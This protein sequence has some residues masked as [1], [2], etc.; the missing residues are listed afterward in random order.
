MFVCGCCVCVCTLACVCKVEEYTNW[1]SPLLCCAVLDAIA[2]WDANDAT[3]SKVPH[4]AC[5][6]GVAENQRGD[7]LRG[8]RIGV[9]KVV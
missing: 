4:T 8:C 6:P 3:S 2:G 5:N 1:N 7:V 9:I